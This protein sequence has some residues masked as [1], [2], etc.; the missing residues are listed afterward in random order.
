[1]CIHL[2]VPLSVGYHKLVLGGSG[3]V[4][5]HTHTWLWWQSGSWSQHG[6]LWV[7]THLCMQRWSGCGVVYVGM[8][9][10]VGVGAWE[11][12]G[13]M[14]VSQQAASPVLLPWV[15][16]RLMLFSLP[17]PPLCLC[18][19]LDWSPRAASSSLSQ[20]PLSCFPGSPSPSLPLKQP[21]RGPGDNGQEGAEWP[22][23]PELGW[24]LLHTADLFRGSILHLLGCM[25][26]PWPVV[27]VYSI[28]LH[29]Y[30]ARSQ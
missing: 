17:P 13:G 8:C 22:Q 1:M 6:Y 10:G 30:M 7:C 24:P 5:V 15:I 21:S 2:S 3:C 27:G 19:S 25:V 9:P 18:P 28:C 4:C 14:C 29:L 12:H 23:A 11:P 16:V 20:T 26:P